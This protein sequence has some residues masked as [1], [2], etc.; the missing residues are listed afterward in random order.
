MADI[1]DV[2]IIGSGAAGYTCAI[3][4]ARYNLKTLVF[5]KELGGMTN[6]AHDIQN[7][8]GF[9]GSGFDLMVQFQNHVKRFGVDIKN[10]VV[11]TITRN[12]DSTFTISTKKSQVQAK[13]IVLAT[14]TERRKLEKPGEAALS[15]KGV[16]YCATCDAFFYR[17]KTVAVVGGGDAATMGAQVLANVAAKVYLIHRRDEFRGDQARVEALR[18]D[19]KVEFLTGVEIES[20]NGEKKVESITL[21]NKKNI[22]LD[23]VF[24]EVGGIPSNELAK[25][26]KLTLDEVGLIQTKEDQSTSV[27]GVY[28]AGDI[29]I[30]SNRFDQTLTASSEGAIASNSL[31]MYLKKHGKTNS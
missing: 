22:V 8:P 20:I 6:L 12:S 25:Q 21:S 1:Y 30:N 28:A 19:S 29:T 24:I 13:T 11:Q 2:V 31:F 3:Y 16:S 14:G 27:P 4:S 26:L 17:G 10:E 7:W 18:K 9:T 23:G 5:G 15:G